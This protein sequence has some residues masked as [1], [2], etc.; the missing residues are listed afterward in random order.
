MEDQT[1]GKQFKRQKINR[2]RPWAQHDNHEHIFWPQRDSE[3]HL[4]IYEWKN[5]KQIDHVLVEADTN[6]DHFL[7]RMK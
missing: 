5:S 4:D 3:G 7:V 1:Q 6:L 2:I